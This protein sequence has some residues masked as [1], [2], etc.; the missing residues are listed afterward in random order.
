MFGEKV[1]AG[2][3]FGRTP[4]GNFAWLNSFE[5]TLNPSKQ[6]VSQIMHKARAG[7]QSLG[8]KVS[9]R[10][11]DVMPLL[12][13]AS[14]RCFVAH[15]ATQAIAPMLQDELVLARAGVRLRPTHGA[16]H[17]RL[18]LDR[19]LQ[20]RQGRQCGTYLARGRRTPVGGSGAQELVS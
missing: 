20:H 19:R 4:A 10:L 17:R 6:P 8:V 9:L 12:S 18:G 11:G 15:A 1:G 7:I 13:P 14:G 16:G 2:L 3:S 5:V